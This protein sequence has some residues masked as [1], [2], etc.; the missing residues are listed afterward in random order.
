MPPAVAPLW[1][2][3]VSNL[4]LLPPT[5]RGFKLTGKRARGGRI[6]LWLTHRSVSSDIVR[7]VHV[8]GD[9]AD[10][11]RRRDMHVEC[12][13]GGGAMTTK[14]FGGQGISNE[15][16]A[17]AAVFDRYRD[18]EQASALQI[19]PIVVGERRVSVRIDCPFRELDCGRRH[20]FDDLAPRRCEQ[21]I[22][23]A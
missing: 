8:V 1:M 4:R 6:D 17:E 11:K 13:R 23:H 10:H 19:F 21:E 3:S 5:D 9:L 2:S 7:Q 18:A 15:V 16:A 20:A 14:L 12:E 22:V